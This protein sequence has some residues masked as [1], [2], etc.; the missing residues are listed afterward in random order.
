MEI[1]VN[2]WILL[3][4]CPPLMTQIDPAQEISFSLR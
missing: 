2:S 1:R 3:Q 4:I